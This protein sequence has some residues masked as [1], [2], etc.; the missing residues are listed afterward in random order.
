MMCSGRASNRRRGARDIAGPSAARGRS[1]SG[2]PRRRAVARD[3]GCRAVRARRS[4]LPRFG[5]GFRGLSEEV[6]AS[7]QRG[8]RRSGETRHVCVN[9]AAGGAVPR[10]HASPRPPP[11]AIR[12]TRA[13]RPCRRS[14]PGR[15]TASRRRA[16]TA[17]RRELGMRARE[18]DPVRY[19]AVDPHVHRLAQARE[20]RREADQAGLR[21]TVLRRVIC[22]PL[23]AG[24]RRDV[25]HGAPAARAHRLKALAGSRASARR[26]SGTASPATRPPRPPGSSPR[27][28]RPRS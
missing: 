26:G 27:P 14:P 7:R 16:P 1:S 25:H 28:T 24:R 9:S 11:R 10:R 18:A 5:R 3:R 8:A 23:H 2:S 6:G 15:R 4:E 13:P 22:A 21:R 19:H 12:R 17:H 20:R